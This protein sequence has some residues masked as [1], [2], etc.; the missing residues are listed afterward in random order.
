M[1]TAPA[2]GQPVWHPLSCRCA[3]CVAIRREERATRGPEAGD[4]EIAVG[5]RRVAPRIVS[6]REAVDG[7]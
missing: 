5:R 7:R 6:P 2:A 1:S 3:E 4:I